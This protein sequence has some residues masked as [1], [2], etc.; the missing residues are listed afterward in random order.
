M[1]FVL[2]GQSR[3]FPQLASPAHLQDLIADLGLKGDRVAIE[4][5]GNIVPRGE[6]ANTSLADGDRLEIVHFVGGGRAGE[7]SLE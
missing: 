4:H 1:H 2:N 7:S 3:D 6:W 5:N